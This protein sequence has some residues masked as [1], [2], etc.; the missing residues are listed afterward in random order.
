MLNKDF[1]K[2]I[3]GELNKIIQRYKSLDGHFKKHARSETNQKSYAFLIWFLEYYTQINGYAP[4]ITDNEKDSSCDLMKE[5]ISDSGR[6]TFCIVQAKWKSESN[7]E[8]HLEEKEIAKALLRFESILNNEKQQVNETVK[9]RIEA[10]QKHI[11]Q[12][13]EVK[14]IFLTLCKNNPAV[15]DE[16]RDF[17][18]RHKKVYIEWWDIE[19]LKRDFIDNEYKDIPPENPF[20]IQE[21]VEE[22]SIN[23]PFLRIDKHDGNFVH[24]TKP[25]ESYIFLIQPKTV[26]DLFNR[27]G[28]KLFFKNVR[29]PLPNSTINRLIEQTATEN[30]PYF[31]YYNNGITA[32]TSHIDTIGTGAEQV[33]IEGLQI[34]NGAQTVHALYEAYKKASPTR[35]RQMD[36]DIMITFRLIR[37]ASKD[38]NLNVTRFN[39]SQNP[40]SGR[41]FHANDEVQ[42]R[43]QDEF[44]NTKVWYEKRQGEF[45]Q[46]PE[47]YVKTAIPNTFFATAYTVFV[48]QDPITP[49]IN[50]DLLFLDDKEHPE[51][52]YNKIFNTATR[53]EQMLA[54]FYMTNVL[55]SSPT[56]V[57]DDRLRRDIYPVL[58][59]SKIALEHHFILKFGDKINIYT[60]IIDLYEKGKTDILEKAL[61]F[62]LKFWM[63]HLEGNTEEEKL[64]FL[65]KALVSQQ[66]FLKVREDWET[67]T[68]DLEVSKIIKP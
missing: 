26:F 61:E 20:E 22:E 25:F 37:S 41:D 52:I 23:L 24:L 35:R 56:F 36:S 6:S 27:Y 1:Y 31:W 55:Y 40:M 50:P 8:T 28:F 12:N 9:E 38:F 68:I 10:L 67:F 59:L 5:H 42:L 16:I 57:Q 2:I 66:H 13:K 53:M 30:A 60:K 65:E 51:G 32:I 64:Q 48:L 33:D 34:I 45:R 11:K 54:S 49:L 39:N 47:N 46:I 21:N 19:R 29:N 62:S 43:L 17:Q 58:A 14:I 18:K 4:Y 7:C 44:F 3:D 15:S 63:E